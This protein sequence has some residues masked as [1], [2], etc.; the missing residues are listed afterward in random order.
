[1][2]FASA[3]GETRRLKICHTPL[4]GVKLEDLVGA[5][6]YLPLWVESETAAK[7]V[8]LVVISHGCMA[9][10]PLDRLNTC[11][12]YTL[13]DDALVIDFC[14]N[15]FATG[16]VVKA[17]DQVH[18]VTDCRQRSTL[19]RRRLPLALVGNVHLQAE[20]LTLLHPLDEV[21]QTTHKLID[22]L[23]LWNIVSWVNCKLLL[24]LLVARLSVFVNELVFW[25]N[26]LYLL[27]NDTT[28]LGLDEPRA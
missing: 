17:T 8:D 10:T 15:D 2:I 22:E 20:T 21:L 19:T 9:L 11:V 12:W 24:F 6:T 18:S 13:P 25:P 5:L 3:G 26:I 16:I 23:I 14:T 1:M 28:R 27:G 7:N 4:V